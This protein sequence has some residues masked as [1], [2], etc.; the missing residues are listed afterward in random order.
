MRKHADISIC[1]CIRVRVWLSKE[2]GSTQ[3]VGVACSLVLAIS[4]G[5]RQ[6]AIQ[7]RGVSHFQRTRINALRC[8]QL[9]LLLKQHLGSFF[10]PHLSGCSTAILATTTEISPVRASFSYC[11]SL[12]RAAQQNPSD[13]P[14]LSPLKALFLSA[15]PLP[16]AV[17]C[18]L[19]CVGSNGS[20]KWR[21]VR[22]A[23]GR[24]RHVRHAPGTHR[25]CCSVVPQSNG[26]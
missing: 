6:T 17:H 5:V 11:I 7:N 15:A 21:L 12:T 26:F 25:L 14:S 9:Q 23:G 13:L 2:S 4:R 24:G 22:R 8:T 1:I 3:G 10:S 19:H 18:S 16:F 20:R